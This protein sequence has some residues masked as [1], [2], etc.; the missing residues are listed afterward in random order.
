[1]SDTTVGLILVLVG[2]LAVIGAIL[3][4]RI[5]TRPGKL[6]NILLGDR[7]ARTIY[8]AVGLFIFA[9]GIGQIFGFHWLGK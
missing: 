6:F 3:N 2:L 8:M 7:V 9:L 1:M 5:V 4:W